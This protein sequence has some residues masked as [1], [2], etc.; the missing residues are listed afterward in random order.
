MRRCH[1]EVHM[2]C[3]CRS[4]NPAVECGPGQSASWRRSA[5]GRGIRGSP[6]VVA[7]AIT[8]HAPLLVRRIER[9][10]PIAR[11]PQRD[12]FGQQPAVR[13]Q[14][15][16]SAALAGWRGGRSR[17]GGGDTATADMDGSGRCS[18]RS[19][20]TISTTTPSGVTAS[21]SGLRLSTSM[22]RSLRL[23]AMMISPPIR[24]RARWAEDIAESAVTAALRR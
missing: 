5:W 23:T 18:G 11:R 3:R 14:I 7:G 6:R 12:G 22:P 9:L 17:T 2:D 8:S 20:F 24:D 16:A 1:V 15:V 13:R 21:A 10:P 4:D 19:P